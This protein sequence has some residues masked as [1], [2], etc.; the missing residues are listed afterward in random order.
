MIH[1]A[2]L[3]PAIMLGAGVGVFT[4]AMFVGGDDEEDVEE[5]AEPENKTP[6]YPQHYSVDKDFDETCGLLEE[7]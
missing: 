2:W 5:D 1:W 7:G 6:S 3:I 4:L